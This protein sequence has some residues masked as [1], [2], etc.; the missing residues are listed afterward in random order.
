MSNE[1]FLEKLGSQ[2]SQSA[3]V[4]NVFGEPVEAGDKTIIPVAQ[5]AYG[6]GGGYGHG[7]DPMKQKESSSVGKNNIGEGA[8]AG[9]GVWA[10]HDRP[11]G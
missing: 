5:I 1:N 3:S 2:F 8:G 9:G 10:A 11:P 4:K 6:Y 7:K